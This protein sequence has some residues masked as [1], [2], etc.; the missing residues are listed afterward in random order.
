MTTQ[1]AQRPGTA[2]VVVE[3]ALHDPQPPLFALIRFIGTPGIGWDEVYLL[4]R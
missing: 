3:K 4:A 1:L 2:L